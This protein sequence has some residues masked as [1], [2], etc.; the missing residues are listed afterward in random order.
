MNREK[1]ANVATSKFKAF[2]VAGLVSISVA[3]LCNAETETSSR[4]LATTVTAEDLGEPCPSK[5]VEIYF[6]ASSDE[7]AGVA[8]LQL[9]W[10]VDAD[11]LKQAAIRDPRGETNFGVLLTETFQRSC[12]QEPWVSVEAAV[13]QTIVHMESKDSGAH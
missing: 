12:E 11:F 6:Q 1:G 13:E 5:L 7:E 10:L 8:I 4:S 3:T 2:V 9:F